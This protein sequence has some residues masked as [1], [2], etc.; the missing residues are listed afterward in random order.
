M[1]VNS[2]SMS[3]VHM[4]LHIAIVVFSGDRSAAAFETP[5]PFGSDGGVTLKRGPYR[6]GPDI[7]PMLITNNLTSVDEFRI[8]FNLKP[9]QMP[10]KWSSLLRFTNNTYDE[11]V[12]GARMPTFLIEGNTTHLATYMGG[13]DWSNVECRH[14]SVTHTAPEL[15]INQ[16]Q[17]VMALLLG[18]TFVTYIDRVM[19]CLQHRFHHRYRSV[20]NV[21]VWLGDEFDPP[22]PVV[23]SNVHYSTLQNPGS[24]HLTNSDAVSSAEFRGA[25]ALFLN[26]SLGLSLEL[27]RIKFELE[28]VDHKLVGSADIVDQVHDELKSL[29]GEL[30]LAGG[31]VGTSRAKLERFQSNL[32]EQD[33]ALQA[34]KEQARVEVQEVEEGIEA[35]ALQIEAVKTVLATLAVSL[36]PG[37]QVAQVVG[38]MKQIKEDM[39]HRKAALE[40][41][42]PVKSQDMG[43]VVDSC[44]ETLQATEAEYIRESLHYGREFARLQ[45]LHAVVSTTQQL[46]KPWREAEQ[47]VVVARNKLSHFIGRLPWL[48]EHV[49][50]DVRVGRQLVQGILDRVKETG[51]SLSRHDILENETER[52]GWGLEGPEGA[53]GH[54]GQDLG[55]APAGYDQHQ[56]L[57]EGMAPETAAVQVPR[58]VGPRLQQ[59][60]SSRRILPSSGRRLMLVSHRTFS[61][62]KGLAFPNAVPSQL[63]TNY[64]AVSALGDS[65]AMDAAAALVEHGAEQLHSAA[66][67]KI[68]VEVR[69][70]PKA[71]AVSL[72]SSLRAE[73]LQ[74]DA[75]ETATQ[76]EEQKKCEQRQLLA[77]GEK[78]SA[79]MRH[80]ELLL[81][82]ASA[83]GK[84]RSILTQLRMLDMH[85][86]NITEV[87]AF[88]SP[89]P[90]TK[91]PFENDTLR[92]YMMQDVADVRRGLVRWMAQ[93]AVHPATIAGI[94][95]SCGR[96]VEGI[97]QAQDETREESDV[98]DGHLEAV[99]A[100]LRA[101]QQD[102]EAER[103]RF[104]AQLPECEEESRIAQQ[105]L[106]EAKQ[107]LALADNHIAESVASCGSVQLFSSR[108]RRE[109]DLIEIGLEL[110]G[111]SFGA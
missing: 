3:S 25:D 9:Y 12:D 75:D 17:E 80:H 20:P 62:N 70:V 78:K 63:P 74:R 79:R 34:S 102:M 68:S 97:R 4:F 86:R 71:D 103:D 6:M 18:D 58:Q 65:L 48:L 13:P 84:V 24:V 30:D 46:R 98:L 93:Q 88:E 51:H 14:D 8:T 111:G 69:R 49:D 77:L 109:Q 96:I 55:E 67:R 47:H 61:A 27:E 101:S 89:R 31:V 11:G 90:Y 92:R 110:L 1:F 54:F 100:V 37:S 39:D 104:E 76:I 44:F 83:S 29:D 72:L 50:G 43:A 81:K 73:L 64:R 38:M 87:L 16:T 66:L 53:E 85:S 28:V 26:I 52:L 107:A 5:E 19:T 35:L 21:S 105:K 23:I 41:E 99:S 82:N 56:F 95:A 36:V 108:R 40:E 106:E 42:L 57:P 59:V 94:N 2:G 22:A 60:R 91:R 32:Q 7:P 15:K 10:E 45:E 33:A